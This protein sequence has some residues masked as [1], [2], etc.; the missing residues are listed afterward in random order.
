MTTFFKAKIVANAL[1][2]I[3]VIVLSI[4]FSIWA[5]NSSPFGDGLVSVIPDFF[6]GCILTAFWILSIQYIF[7]DEK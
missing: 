6:I 1:K 2:V 3:G 5:T 7:K 4:I